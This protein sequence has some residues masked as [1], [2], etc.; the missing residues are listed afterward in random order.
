MTTTKRFNCV[1]LFD[2]LNGF[3]HDAQDTDHYGPNN[4]FVKSLNKNVAGA[5]NDFKQASRFLL[6]YSRKSEATYNRFRNEIERFLLWTWTIANKSVIELKRS[7]IEAYIDFCWKPDD[8]WISKEIVPRFDLQQGRRITNPHWRPFTIKATKSQRAISHASG[9]ELKISK[10]NYNV[11]QSTL[12][13]IFTAL[14]VFFKDLLIEEYA[15]A[16]YIP[17]VK[18]RC[19]YL[20]NNVKQQEVQRLSELQWEFVLETARNLADNNSRYERHLFLVAS[21]KSLYLRISE[22]GVRNSPVTGDPEWVPIMSHF[23]SK[24]GYW[25][26][27]V[28][29]KGRKARVVTIPEEFLPYLKRYR[30]SRNLLGLPSRGENQPIINKLKGRG[31]MTSRQ[32]TRLVQEIFDAAV[33]RMHKEGFEDQAEELR[34]ATT[35]WLRHTGASQ[36]VS[37]RPLK[38]LADD[39]GHASMGTTDKIYI[40]SDLRERARSGAKRKV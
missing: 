1:P 21:L 26:L 28:F 39:L 22:L 4:S 35:H 8:H 40:Q 6:S 27:E 25:F 16:N 34:S 29:G 19:P 23:Y 33:D 3:R 10:A 13:S 31:A 5:T 12:Q 36:D 30:E 38:H 32:L 2:S 9:K 14:N 20:V 37:S 11:S 17:I 15:D 24:E 18:K 7:D